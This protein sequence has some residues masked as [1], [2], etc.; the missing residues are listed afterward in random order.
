MRYSESILICTPCFLI[1][2]VFLWIAYNVTGVIVA[3]GKYDDFVIPFLADLAKPGALLDAESNM[4]TVTGIGQAICTMIINGYFRQI[5][6]W[7]T[8]RENHKYQS[9]YDNS[10]I[11]KRVIFEFFD[12][13]LPLIYFGWWDLNF[14]V[15]R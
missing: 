12:C 8:D 10:L 9:T 15:L 2:L 1:V 4:G 5:A 7:L 13:F 11:I 3:D 6:E 14:K